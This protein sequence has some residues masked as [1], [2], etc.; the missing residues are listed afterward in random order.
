VS[1]ACLL[2]PSEGSP[3]VTEKLRCRDGPRI[4]SAIYRKKRSPAGTCGVKGP[5][6]TLFSSPGF[7]LQNYGEVGTT[8]LGKLR[9]D[10]PMPIPAEDAGSEQTEP[11]IRSQRR[12]NHDTNPIVKPH[13]VTGRNCD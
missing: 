13:D 6:E 12:A 10:E 11:E 7:P 3:A 4:N 9:C 2:S 5:C 8:E 1:D